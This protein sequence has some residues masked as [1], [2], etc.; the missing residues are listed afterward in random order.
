MHQVAHL[1]GSHP[2]G[3]LSL[4]LLH[5]AGIEHHVFRSDAKGD[6]EE[7]REHLFIM[8][9]RERRGGGGEGLSL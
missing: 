4:I 8:R 7:R 2:G 5:L 1:L 3:D 9:K 6:G